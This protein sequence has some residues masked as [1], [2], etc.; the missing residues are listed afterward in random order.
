MKHIT[1]FHQKKVLVLGL[2]KSGVAAAT[3][4]HDLG[5]F[6]TVND[7]KERSDNDEA[8]QLE[9]RGITV[10][11]GGHPL[12]LLDGVDLLIKNPG[13]PYKNVIV[14]EALTRNIPV[15]TEVELAYRIADAEMIAITGSNGKTTTTTLV[16]EMLEKSKRTPLV[17]GNI[18]TVVTD[19]ARTA[20]DTDVIVVEL[21]SFQLMGTDAF[22]PKI[23]VWLNVFDAHLDYHGTRSEYVEAKARIMKNLTEEETLV[24]NAD[25]ETVVDAASHTHANLVPF[26]TKK[27]VKEGAYLDQGAIYFQEEYIIELEEVVLPGAHNVENMLASIAAVKLAGGTNEQIRHVLSTF[28]GVKHRLQFVGEWKNR[29]IYNDS[30]ATNILATKAALSAFTKPVVLIAGG[31]DRGNEF[32]EILPDFSHVQ[33]L[34]AYGQT[35]EKL[36]RLGGKAGVTVIEADDVKDATKKA[37]VASRAGQVILLSPACASWDQYRSFEERGDAFL[38]T[39]QLMINKDQ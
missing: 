9:D 27:I 39:V 38:E 20:T 3:M 14:K 37:I 34:V 13:I 4:M 10:V 36:V 28:K 17:A 30:K 5:A 15:W 26:S 11:S 12:H 23:A 1:E 29:L 18:G 8:S 7:S 31:L 22:R 2:A 21:S 25:D 35:K 33:V 19:V 24:Y 32:D 6:V 16:A